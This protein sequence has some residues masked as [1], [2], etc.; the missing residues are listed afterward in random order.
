M[1][2]VCKKGCFGEPGLG[3]DHWPSEGA[4]PLTLGV[5]WT[6][7]TPAYYK[8]QRCSS[9]STLLHSAIVKMK[10]VTVSLLF[11]A[12]VQRGFSSKTLI[13]LHYHYGYN[14]LCLLYLQRYQQCLFF[15]A[16][17][18]GLVCGSLWLR[19]R[20]QLLLSVQPVVPAL[21]R[22]LL[23]LQSNVWRWTGVKKFP[24]LDFYWTCAIA[25]FLFPSQ[26]GRCPAT[27]GAVSSTTRRTSATATP[28]AASTA[29]AVVTMQTSAVR[30]FNKENNRK[31]WSIS[32]ILQRKYFPDF[33]TFLKIWSA[34]KVET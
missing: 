34:S 14:S 2:H 27:A 22:L 11:L 6:R 19:N 23:W 10:L 29:T 31:N 17:L 20:Q 28:S 13:L 21:Q 7:L 18:S 33:N 5:C 9:T 4:E 24:E 12:L 30:F 8:R 32:S 3:K 26:M 25:A 15:T 1:W 16:R